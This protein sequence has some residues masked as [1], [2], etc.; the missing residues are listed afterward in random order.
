MPMASVAT[1]QSTS[2]A[3]N[4]ATCALRV[5][6]ESAPRTTAAPPLRARIRSAIS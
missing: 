6:G 4:I 2:P 1:S 3:W 5:R